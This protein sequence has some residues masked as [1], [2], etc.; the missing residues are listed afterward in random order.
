VRTLTSGDWLQLGL[1]GLLLYALTQG[2][3]FLTLKHLDAIPFSLILSFTPI[4]VAGTSV[5]V[6]RE[7]PSRL[8][9]IGLI[10]T[11]AGAAIYFGP[12]N[13]F[14]GEGFGFL[15]AGLTLLAGVFASLL[16]RAV[17]RRRTASPIVVTSIS[18]SCGAAILLGVGLGTQGLPGLTLQGWGIVGWLAVVNTALAFTI[19]NRTLRVLSATESSVINNTMLIQIAVLAWIF[20]GER[21]GAVEILGLIAVA[22]GTLLV[23][24]RSTRRR[25]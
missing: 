4:F 9:W 20:L 12:T 15:L 6:L 7:R 22:A 8:Q 16:G 5:F 13:P 19:W 25:Q 18:M 14:R 24:L 21:L 2:C 17:N 11:L 3:Q 1:L 23:Q 10:L